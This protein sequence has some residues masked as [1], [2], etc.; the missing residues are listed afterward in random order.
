MSQ[1]TTFPAASPYSHRV[2]VRRLEGWRAQR[3]AVMALPA[4]LALLFAGLGA[5]LESEAPGAQE[6]IPHEM[7]CC[8]ARGS[9]VVPASPS[10]T[11]G[12][13]S[14][15]RVIYTRTES[16]MV[17]VDRVLRAAGSDDLGP[18]ERR[19]LGG[20]LADLS[21]HY[22]YD[23]ALIVAVIM[24]ES[25]FDPSSRSRKGALGL[26]QLLPNT[27]EQLAAETNRPWS[28]EHGLFDPT[29]NISLGVRYLAQLQ[30]RF[31]SLDLALAAY[32][33]GPA[34]VD[35]FLRHGEPVPTEYSNRVLARYRV[36]Q[37]AGRAARL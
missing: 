17:Q 18:A 26:M 23:P 16:R 11:T 6:V 22:G 31:G 9:A 19:R 29:Y 14:G 12:S 33:Y 28:G 13:S 10:V 24:T 1:R 2:F 4:A 3:A 35:E 34:R 15:F 25:S 30:K 5:V 36:L 8:V 7:F 32:N 21:E 20:V 37:T 27:A